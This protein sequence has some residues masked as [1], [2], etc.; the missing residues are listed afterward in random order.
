[1]AERERAQHRLQQSEEQ[2]RRILDSALDAVIT[3]DGDGVITSWNEQAEK[4][5]GWASSEA[6]G[7][8][9]AE[10]IISPD[11]RHMCD[12]DM[13]RLRS[14]RRGSVVGRRFDTTGLRRDGREFPVEVSVS[15]F[16]SGG[17][18]MFCGFL[19]DLTEMKRVEEELHQ[20][21]DELARISRLSVVTEL[22]ASIAHEINQP[23]CAIVANSDT[24]LHWLRIATPDIAKARAAAQRLANDARRVSEIITHIRMLTNKTTFERIPIDI[25]R[26]IRDVL[27]LA[28]PK[29]RSASITTDTDLLGTIPTISGDRIQLQQIVLNLISN[30]IESMLLVSDRPRI[31][32]IRSRAE[33]GKVVVAF[34]DNG[35]GLDPATADRVFEAFFTT[36]RHGTGIG[37]AICRSIIEAHDGT[38]SAMHG[39]PH[40]A[41][42]QFEL[43]AIH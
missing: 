21:R 27:Q 37:L 34:H 30:S 35:I 23:L 40:G 3:I 20:A 28:Q 24:C 18:S 19:R 17:A 9:L 32:S 38:I 43:P 31:L 16:K 14:G 25:N 4:T 15:T 10:L 5:F 42:F 8:R 33:D 6:I 1:M 13:R 12:Q 39:V 26:I 11:L 22:T 41:I 2:L 7:Y 29:L 36:K